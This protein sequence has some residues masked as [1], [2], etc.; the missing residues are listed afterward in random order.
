MLLIFHRTVLWV[1]SILIIT[2]TG[3]TQDKGLC[4]PSGVKPETRIANPASVH[5]IRSGGK[6]VIRRN[7]DGGE[8]GVCVFED[9]REC[10]EWALFRGECPVGGLDVKTFTTDDPFKYCA[11]IGTID[12][13][14]ARYTGKGTPDPIVERM[15]KEGILSADAPVQF[16]RNFVWRCMDHRVWVCVYGANI[17]CTEKADT[18]KVPSPEMIDYC[19]ANPSTDNIPA[20]VTGRKTV[21]A[22]RCAGGNPR[23]D[24]QIHQVDHEGYIKTY[25]YEFK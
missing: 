23:I 12:I 17:P 10:E 6:L 14:D 16:Q 24:R 25:W 22:W 7:K 8:Y 3:Y 15:I 1:L 20:Y 11:V 2:A 19:G 21:Y 4:C 9:N 5:C 13:P 18:S